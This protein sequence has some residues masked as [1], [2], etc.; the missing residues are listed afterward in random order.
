M[1]VLMV[2]ME[3]KCNEIGC[4]GWKVVLMVGKWF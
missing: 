2:V 1:V 4:Y 3:R